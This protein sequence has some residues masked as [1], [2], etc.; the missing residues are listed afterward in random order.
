MS[1]LLSDDL[2]QALQLEGTPLTL[3][4]PETGETYVLVSACAYETA[5]TMSSEE[6]AALERARIP[7]ACLLD[8]AKSHAPPPSWLD[9]EEADLF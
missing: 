6:E 5:Q 8:L 7:N 1:L 9:G 2:R 4:D 3:V